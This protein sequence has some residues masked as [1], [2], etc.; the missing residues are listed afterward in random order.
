MGAEAVV[1]VDEAE[2][3]ADCGAELAR[4]MVIRCKGGG[5]GKGGRGHL[6]QQ[7]EW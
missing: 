7:E 1:D 2:G 4:E 6:Q 3:G 5:K